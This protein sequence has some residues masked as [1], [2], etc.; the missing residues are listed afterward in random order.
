MS[1]SDLASLGSFV[2]GVA[3]LISL[4]YLALQVRQAEKN[5]RALVQQARASRI[6]DIHLRLAEPDMAAVY[7][8]GQQ[9]EDLS[10]VEFHQFRNSTRAFLAHAEDVFLQHQDRLV[11]ARS[12]SSF[13]S[14]LGRA[15]AA[16]G[17]RAMWRMERERYDKGFRAFVDQLLREHASARAEAGPDE[18]RAAVAAEAN[19]A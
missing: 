3:V 12:Y 16:R 4:V 2:S 10:A 19:A 9:G 13:R 6:A 7:V 5:Q 17:R 11:S 1:L 8:K 15:M 18:W 14:S